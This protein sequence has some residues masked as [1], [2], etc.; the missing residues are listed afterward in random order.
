MNAAVRAVARTALARRWEV[1]G[2]EAGYRGL[3]EGRFRS[4][5]NCGVGGILHRGGTVFGTARSPKFTTS[6]GK[7]RVAK[8]LEER[9]VAVVGL[10]ATIDNDVWGT[11]TAIGVDTGHGIEHRTRSHRPDKGH[12]PAPTSGP[13]WSR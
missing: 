11:D 1:V 8:R 10:P 5:G 9:G 7:G 2:I 12:R 3:L 4:L 13:T 6:Q